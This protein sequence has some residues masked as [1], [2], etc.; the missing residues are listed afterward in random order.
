[1]ILFFFFFWKEYM[2]RVEF[3]YQIF[4]YDLFLAMNILKINNVNMHFPT[5]HVIHYYIPL[6]KGLQSNGQNHF[7]IPSSKG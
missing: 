2:L 5:D 4:N 1:M 3:D 7:C 6:I